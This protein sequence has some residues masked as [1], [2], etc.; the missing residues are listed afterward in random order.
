MPWSNSAI[1]LT[2]ELS[3]TPS[4]ALRFRM[5]GVGI[6]GGD[7]SHILACLARDKLCRPHICRVLEAQRLELIWSPRPPHQRRLLE[8]EATLGSTD[9]FLHSG[10]F[11]GAPGPPGVPII[12]RYSSA[13]AIHWSS[14]DPGKGPI[15][16]YVIEARPSGTP[17]PRVG[18]LPSMAHFL[19]RS[20]PYPWD[21]FC[22]PSTKAHVL[23]QVKLEV[24][25]RR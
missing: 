16:R 19:P 21:C 14:G 1:E 10:M 9:T 24:G 18:C 6:T 3:C 11:S 5:W 15:T 12:A 17:L 23:L 7:S 22:P 25:S 8:R 4:L 13:I 20:C 2:P